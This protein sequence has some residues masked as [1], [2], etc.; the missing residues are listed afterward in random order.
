MICE[1]CEPDKFFDTEDL[2]KSTT[3]VL[4]MKPQTPEGL[5]DDGDINWVWLHEASI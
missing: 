2:R 3:R 5:T 4:N 1:A